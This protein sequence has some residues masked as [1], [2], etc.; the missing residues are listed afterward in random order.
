M[1]LHNI[2]IDS[3][4]HSGSVAIRSRDSTTYMYPFR[5]KRDG[6]YALG[7]HRFKLVLQSI[8]IVAKLR[9]ISR[10]SDLGVSEEQQLWFIG[11]KV[12]VHQIEI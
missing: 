3:I 10:R 1:V 4:S 6:T 12:V 2:Y 7:V 8:S 11:I 9:C 5:L